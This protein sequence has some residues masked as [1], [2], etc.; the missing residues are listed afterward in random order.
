MIKGLLKNFQSILQENDSIVT[1]IEQSKDLTI[2]SVAELIGSLE[3][4]KKRL[5]ATKKT[6]LRVLFS[7]SL[8][9]GLINLDILPRN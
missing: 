9:Q 8:M 6:L 7:L 2:L 3:A 4:H 1:S 5:G